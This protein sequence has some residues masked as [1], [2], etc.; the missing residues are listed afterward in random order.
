METAALAAHLLDDAMLVF[1]GALS[2]GLR[3]GVIGFADALH[4]LG[5]AYA[6]AGA[7]VQARTF[8]IALAEGCLRGAIEL[9]EERGA[10]EATPIDQLKLW[11]LREM[12]VG[13]V[14]RASRN[15]VR[16]LIRTAIRNHPRLAMLADNTTDAIDP[17]PSAEGDAG[18][19]NGAARSE[20]RNAMQPW[21]DLPIECRGCES[22]FA[23]DV[24]LAEA[25]NTRST[26][27]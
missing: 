9:A 2:G 13:L 26:T 6:S 3:I 4:K 22:T 12:P 24:I 27:R 16:H 1:G 5:I 11:R 14:E 19:A 7:C 25:G 21:I 15:G 8:A 17:R 20:I 18:G 10:P 23:G